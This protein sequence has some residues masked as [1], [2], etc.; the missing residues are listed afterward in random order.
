MICSPFLFVLCTEGLTHLMIIEEQEGSIK[1]IQFSPKGPSICHLL[2]AN[3]ICFMF[4]DNIQQCSKM[5]SILG[6][7]GQLMGQVINLKNTSITFGERY[8]L[9]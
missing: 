2:F 9:I 5:Q 1:G 7:Y 8:L 6:P 3:D 4:R